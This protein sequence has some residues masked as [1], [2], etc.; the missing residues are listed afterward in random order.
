MSF[1]IVSMFPSID[2]KAGLDAVKS[3]LLKRCCEVCFIKNQAFACF[4]LSPS[5]SFWFSFFAI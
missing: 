2:N 5:Y 3:V 1:D 4:V